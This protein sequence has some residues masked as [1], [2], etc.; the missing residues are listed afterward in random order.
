MKR[1][2]RIG[3]PVLGGLSLPERVAEHRIG[4]VLASGAMVVDTRPAAD[5]AMGHIPGTLS[6]PF[7]K[8]FATWAGS[9]LPYQSDIY[10]LVDSVRAGLLRQIL[11]SLMMIGLDRI[12]GYFGPETLELWSGEGKPLESVE[13]LSVPDLALKRSALFVLDVRGRAEWEGGHIR[14]ALHIP[15]AELPDR[16]AEVPADQ[17]LAVHCQGGGRSAIA[18]AFLA[19]RGRRAVSNL[20]G[21]FGAW[22]DAGMPVER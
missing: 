10:L 12:R 11:E 15:L 17:P 5:F 20:A 4:S 9:L 19:A 16:L 8:S 1:V 7:N 22:R 21:G 14:G 6:I 18:A 3:P 13:Q 2:N